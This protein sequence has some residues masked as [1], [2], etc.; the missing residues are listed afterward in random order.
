MTEVRNKIVTVESLRAVHM[1]NRNTYVS[2][3]E[4]VLCLVDL[5]KALLQ[6]N[7]NDFIGFILEI[8]DDNETKQIMLTNKINNDETFDVIAQAFHFDED[9][10]MFIYKLYF[11]L[12]DNA[13]VIDSTLTKVVMLTGQKTLLPLSYG[14]IYGVKYTK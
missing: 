1:Y 5:E 6:Y 10:N 7:P 13:Y 9:M 8:K 3:D 12:I 4:N 2:K 14:K 11:H